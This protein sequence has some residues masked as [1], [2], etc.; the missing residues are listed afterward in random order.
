[1]SYAIQ[2]CLTATQ[3][4]AEAGGDAVAGACDVAAVV[5]CARE[6]P[7][8]AVRNAALGALASLATLLPQRALQH[9]LEV[10]LGGDASEFTG[11]VH[12]PRALG[13]CVALMGCMVFSPRSPRAFRRP[14]SARG[15]KEGCGFGRTS[16]SGLGFF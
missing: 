16:T 12:W 14:V 15:G 4:L 5:R 7:D 2:L 9:V 6:A 11:R 1:V 10:C 3:R 8:A 13:R